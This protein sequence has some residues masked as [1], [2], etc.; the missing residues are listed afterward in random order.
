MVNFS[1]SSLSCSRTEIRT[2]SL[3]PHRKSVKPRSCR[4]SA[5]SVDPKL[6]FSYSIALPQRTT[7]TLSTRPAHLMTVFP[8]PNSRQVMQGLANTNS[9]LDGIKRNPYALPKFKKNKYIGLVSTS[10]QPGG[11]NAVA[12]NCSRDGSSSAMANASKGARN[13]DKENSMSRMKVCYYYPASFR[14]TLTVFSLPTRLSLTNLYQPSLA[15][16]PS[17]QKAPRRRNLE[18]RQIHS[19]VD[20]TPPSYPSILLNIIHIV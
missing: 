13:S 3:V 9:E 17:W 5:P 18:M 7:T 11:I 8:T 2:R 1:P 14:A 16:P 12:N 19:C 10:A 6:A 15:T 20:R 4:S